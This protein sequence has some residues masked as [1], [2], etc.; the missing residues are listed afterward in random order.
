MLPFKPEKNKE[1]SKRMRKSMK[2]KVKSIR[3]EK[4]SDSIELDNCKERKG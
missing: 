2:E 1:K 3:K 4:N